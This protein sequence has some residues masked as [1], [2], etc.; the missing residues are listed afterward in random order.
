MSVMI[1]RYSFHSGKYSIPEVLFR[2]TGRDGIV[3]IRDLPV[4]VLDG[5]C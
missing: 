1:M 2:L 3:K 5:S 4:Y